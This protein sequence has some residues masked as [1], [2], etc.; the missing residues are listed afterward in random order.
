LPRARRRS[1]SAS[2]PGGGDAD[3]GGGAPVARGGGDE[4]CRGA[5]GGVLGGRAGSDGGWVTVRTSAAVEPPSSLAAGSSVG[6]DGAAGTDA[7]GGGASAGAGTA[8]GRRWSRSVLTR[9]TNALER[10]S[11]LVKRSVKPP[12]PRRAFG[13]KPTTRPSPRR[14]TWPDG[15]TSSNRRTTPCGRGCA[16]MSVTLVRVTASSSCSKKSSSVA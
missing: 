4:D 7:G 1:R 16:P 13:L 8:D 12:S 2:R 9:S 10:E 14:T 6:A 3:C 15:S 5:R 11:S